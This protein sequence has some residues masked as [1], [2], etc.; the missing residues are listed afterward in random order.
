MNIQL[1]PNY[2][3][4]EDASPYVI[5]EIGSN[6]N[7]DMKLAIEHIEA[8]V[9]CGAHAAKFQ[10]FSSKSLIARE[11][12]EANEDY[13]DKK[14][15]FGSLK[16]MVEAY[17]LTP[18]QHSEMAQ[19][20]RD[21]GIDF[22][23]T[24]FCEAETDLLCELDVPFL[25]IPSMDVTHPRTLRHAA[26]TGK[27]IVLSTGMADLGEV[28]RAI[29]IIEG[30][31]NKNIILLHCIAIYPPDLRDIHLNNMATL[32]QAFGYPVGFSDHSIGTHIPLAA[33]ALGACIIE[34]HFTLDREMPGWDHDISADPP[35]MK[36]ICDG[37]RDIHAA[38]GSHRR[39]VSEAELQKRTRF[40]RSAIAVKDLSAGHKLT[41]E[42]LVYKRPGTAIPP[43]EE[44]WLVGHEL[45]RDLKADDIIRRTDLR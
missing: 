16:E 26:R 12:Y 6:H 13:G 2:Q 1:T 21:R 4:S 45:A 25:K 18:E 37:A 8:A 30:E 40:R 24:P 3:V 15:H 22:I 9:E 11:E 17:Q 23:S 14:K 31:G 27:P 32:R 36:T 41:P 42:D 29:N 5:A 20:C 28:E 34:K 7:G 44:E 10:S 39:V 35:Q 19:A 33:V 38:L 43:T